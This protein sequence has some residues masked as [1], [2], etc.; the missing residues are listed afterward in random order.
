VLYLHAAVQPL[1]HV[2]LDYKIK[3]YLNWVDWSETEQSFPCA[4]TFGFRSIT[5]WRD[6]GSLSGAHIRTSA[7]RCICKNLEIAFTKTSSSDFK[8]ILIL[9]NLLIFYR[10]RAR[11]RL[12]SS[13]VNFRITT[14]A[15]NFTYLF[16]RKS[17]KKVTSCHMFWTCVLQSLRVFFCCFETENVRRNSLCITYVVGNELNIYMHTDVTSVADQQYYN[18]IVPPVLT[19]ATKS[20][21]SY[22]CSATKMTLPFLGLPTIEIA[23]GLDLVIIII[24]GTCCS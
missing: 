9:H 7:C 13:I 6:H 11:A 21:F 8:G 5:S 1:A 18:K 22:V 12:P 10:A 15:N 19:S 4:H 17:A 2:V 23:H 14:F 16:S 3:L 24:V 20:K